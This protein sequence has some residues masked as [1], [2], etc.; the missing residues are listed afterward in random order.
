MDE[1]SLTG[2][3]V[4]LEPLGRQHIDGL[5]KAA[6]G[7]GSLFQWSLVPKDEDEV[8]RYVGTALSWRDA[9]TAL[10]FAIVRLSDNT[11]IGSTRF[12]NIER[13]AWPIGHPSHGRAGPMPARLVTRGSPN[14][15]SG[16]RRIQ[17]QRNFS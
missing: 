3:H 13:W 6:T 8:T 15:L 2:S 5:L 4:G 7:N 12:W 17:S 9:G 16:L 1:L 14:R 11:V 10:S